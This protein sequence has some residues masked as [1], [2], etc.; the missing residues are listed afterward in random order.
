MDYIRTR[1]DVCVLRPTNISGHMRTGTNLSLRTH[2]GKGG[3][4]AQLVRAWDM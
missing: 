3:E 4:L 1:A 2:C